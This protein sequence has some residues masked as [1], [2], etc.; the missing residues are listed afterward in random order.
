MGN[1]LTR[2]D[3]FTHA[4]LHNNTGIITSSP[5]GVCAVDE[6]SSGVLRPSSTECAV[7]SNACCQKPIV[8]LRTDSLHLKEYDIQQTPTNNQ[9]VQVPLEV[10]RNT[11]STN[12]NEPSRPMTFSIAPVT[13]ETGQ[14][15]KW[16]KNPP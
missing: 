10:K 13:I 11:Q 8:A 7:C 1:E 9:A 6:A 15:T 16:P 5:A 12:A 4:F 3:T 14:E 2:D